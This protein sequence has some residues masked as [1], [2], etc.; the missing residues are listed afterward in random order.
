MKNI[1]GRKEIREV[2][3]PRPIDLDILLFGEE[4]IKSDKLT[5]P[6]PRML[7]RD[8]VMLP[9][10]E[11]A[12]DWVIPGSGCYSSRSSKEIFDEEFFNSFFITILSLCRYN[13]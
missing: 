12:S 6:H 1:L 9:L 5:V 3:S 7:N 13:Y 4:I 2:N 8:F 11:I 10:N